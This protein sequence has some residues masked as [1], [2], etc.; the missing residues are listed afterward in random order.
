MEETAFFTQVLGITR[1]WYISRAELN[2]KKDRVDIYI[3]HYSEFAFPCP[4]C[5]KLCSVKGHTNERIF[6]H[7]NVCQMAAFIHVRF[8]RIKCPKHGVLQIV[9]ELG[10]ENSGMTFKFDNLVLGLEQEYSLEGVSRLLNLNWHSCWGVMERAVERGQKR[11]AHRIPQRIGVD[12]KSFSKGH[13]YETLV[14]DLDGS[15]VEYVG[16]PPRAEKP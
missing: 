3:E 9:S 15:T 12:E 6:S 11:K 5:R 13:R 16:E 10:E 8:P 14:Y 1:P 7:L 2:K 4:K